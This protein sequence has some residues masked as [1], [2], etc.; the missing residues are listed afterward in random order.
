MDAWWAGQ[1]LA[2]LLRTLR[3]LDYPS[4]R[5][6]AEQVD[7][8]ELVFASVF[9]TAS[10]PRELERRAVRL[11]FAVVQQGA[12]RADPDEPEIGEATFQ[13]HVVQ[14]SE[15]SYTGSAAAGAH[16]PDG[17]AGSRGRGVREIAGRV[18]RMVARLGPAEGLT[19]LGWSEGGGSDYKVGD[20]GILVSA[21]A[22]EV[23]VRTYSEPDFP[24]PT[25]LARAGNIA[26]WTSPGNRFDL[27]RYVVRGHAAPPS[28]STT[29]PEAGTSI[30]LASPLDLSVDVTGFAAIVLFAMFRPYGN[31]AVEVPSGGVVL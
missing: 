3:H 22:I 14:R 30:A 7:A 25:R 29:T 9:D 26:S 5:A 24:R 27:A 13:L 16:R 12:V 1:Q 8:G 21:Q 19:I 18:S 10:D 2:Y 15:A 17:M 23:R 20:D 31:S 4:R 11:P 6:P 28:A